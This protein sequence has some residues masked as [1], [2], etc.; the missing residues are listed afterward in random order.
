MFDGQV[1]EGTF[2]AKCVTT[3]CRNSFMSAGNVAYS[4]A[5]HVATTVFEFFGCRR[6]ERGVPIG[7]DQPAVA[8]TSDR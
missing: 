3:G 7:L 2:S 5:G 4:P 6:R 8:V 1:E